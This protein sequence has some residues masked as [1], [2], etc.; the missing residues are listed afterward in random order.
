[1]LRDLAHVN[2]EL[3]DDLAALLEL[4]DAV[5]KGRVVGPDGA[6]STSSSMRTRASAKEEVSMDNAVKGGGSALH[7]PRSNVDRDTAS[8]LLCTGQHILVW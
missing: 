4:T 2:D 8:Y 5:H 3:L 6:S 7:P 1:M